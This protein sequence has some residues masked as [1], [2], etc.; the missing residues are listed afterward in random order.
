[1]CSKVPRLTESDRNQI[2]QYIIKQMTRIQQNDEHWETMLIARAVL[3][4]L[5]ADQEG[6]QTIF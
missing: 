4:L 1:M 5:C 2:D 3:L 6:V